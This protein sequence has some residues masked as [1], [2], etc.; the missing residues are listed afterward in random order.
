MRRKRLRVS[1]AVHECEFLELLVRYGRGSHAGIDGHEI[2]EIDMHAEQSVMR[3]CH[4]QWPAVGRC[5]PKVVISHVI[6]C[7]VWQ[8]RAVRATV[9]IALLIQYGGE[10]VGLIWHGQRWV[11]RGS[12]WRVLHGLSG[13]WVGFD[14]MLL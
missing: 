3:A 14:S 4:G 13:R 6:R 2:P 11:L 10:T 7:K 1:R 5:D 9:D 8:G 12:I